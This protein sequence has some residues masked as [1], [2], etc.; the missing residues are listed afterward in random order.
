MNLRNMLLAIWVIFC[1][2]RLALPQE[3]A[4]GAKAQLFRYPPAV[5][6]M[7]AAGKIVALVPIAAN[8]DTFVYSK[9][10]NTLYV[11]HEAGER[12]A[13][14]LSAVNLTTQ[15]VD[16]EI[17]VGAG[18]GVSLL[19]SDDGH[20]LFCYTIGS[21][22]Q[23][24]AQGWPIPY[25]KPPFE[26]A[27]NVID[28][29]SNEVIATYE[30][31]DRFPAAARK[32]GFFA[33][34]WL[35]T[36]DGARLIVA[37]M[38]GKY[39]CCMD[40]SQVAIFAGQSPHPTFTID[41]DGRIAGLMLSRND[42]TL[43]V[44]VEKKDKKNPGSLD[45]I[46]LETGSTATRAL[47]ERPTK[48]IR[49][50]SDRELWVLGSKEMRSVSETGDLG[51]QPISL[52]DR[53][54]TEALLVANRNDTVPE[55]GQSAPT[56]GVS[57]ERFAAIDQIVILPVFAPGATK[58]GKVDLQ[59]MRESTQ[60]LLESK[61]YAVIQSDNNGGVGELVEKDLIEARTEWIKRLGPPEARYV[62]TIELRGIGYP[63]NTPTAE[64]LGFLYDKES[65][66]V[67]WEGTSVGQYVFNVQQGMNLAAA[68]LTDALWRIAGEARKDAEKSA[69]A[70]LLSSIPKLPKEK[71]N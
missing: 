34:N 10:A 20:R 8:A 30:W 41:P 6:V 52:K 45:I 58:E 54:A 43:F 47:T 2:G 23:L 22:N 35:A 28:T 27:I 37:S 14:F 17:K 62:M 21:A 25:I 63:G 4:A 48:L 64:A 65:G 68:G 50:G 57:Q 29:A 40:S 51:D 12:E 59:L 3:L 11:A 66:S 46:D 13:R 5:A 31:L 49:L 38:A 7:D 42:K 33:S 16:R 1:S 61:H 26:P 53:V 60:K 56:V 71:K 24:Q 9:S 55:V 39:I 70:N 18:R 44:A 15:R 69:V 32:Y 36:R 19:M 67:L